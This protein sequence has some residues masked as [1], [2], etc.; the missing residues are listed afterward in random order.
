MNHIKKSHINRE[1]EEQENNK[2]KI[3]SNDLPP[4]KKSC[5]NELPSEV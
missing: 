4:Q 2:R 5:L 3:I 1:P